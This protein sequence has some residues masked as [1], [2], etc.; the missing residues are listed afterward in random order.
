MEPL[1]SQPVGEEKPARERRQALRQRVHTPAYASFDEGSSALDLNEI[2]DISEAGV[3]IQTAAALEVNR[4]LQLCLDLSETGSRIQIPAS[5]IWTDTVGRAGIRIP[6]LPD[7]SRRELQQWL[8]HNALAGCAPPSEAGESAPSAGREAHCT[9]EAAETVPA[10]YTALLSALPIVA[11][12]VESI[13]PDLDAALLLIAQRALSFTRAGGVAIAF[14]EGDD[15]ICHAAAGVDAPPLGARFPI[16]SGFSGECVRTGMLLRC[17][18]SEIDSRVDKEV[19]RALGIRSMAAVP[20]RLAG[21]VIGLLEIFSPAPHSFTSH[22]DMV[23]QR[24]A[25]IIV[26]AVN[27]AALAHVASR[28]EA[29]ASVKDDAL[30]QDSA[31]PLSG[32]AGAIQSSMPRYQKILLIAAAAT[33]LLVLIFLFS[34]WLKPQSLKRGA[35][36]ATVA[37]TQSADATPGPR[38]VAEAATLGDLQKLAEQGDAYAQFA[39][40]ARYATGEDVKQDYGEA[41]RWFTKAAEQGHVVAQATLGAYYWAGRGVPQDL[42]KAYFWSI[43]A[44][45]GGD[46]ASKYRV[47]VLTSRMTHA[48]VLAAQQQADDWLGHHQIAKQ[49]S[50]RQ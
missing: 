24:L 8:F 26:A 46:E 30:P 13:G 16:G 43:L 32:I 27:R 9:M 37:P 12:E 18:D 42:P 29:T 38:T 34:P 45:A 28:A 1:E 35:P 19:C 39:I 14:R 40:G 7:E 44:R 15:L 48:Q 6:Q 49:Q 21:R 22:D 25:E 47:A 10:D 36:D 20:I 50:S 3:A 11:G 33:I 23:L 2:L 17:D 31:G 5:V 4:S 41:V